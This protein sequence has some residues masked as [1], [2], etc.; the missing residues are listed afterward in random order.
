MESLRSLNHTRDQVYSIS[1]KLHVCV[2][3]LGIL[4]FELRKRGLVHLAVI[5]QRDKHSA[6]VCIIKVRTA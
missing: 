5:I 4:F 6:R 2:R 1:I 3:M